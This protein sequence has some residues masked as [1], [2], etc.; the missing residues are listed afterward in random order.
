[1]ANFQP[2]TRPLSQLTK[3]GRCLGAQHPALQHRDGGSQQPT[4]LVPLLPPGGACRTGGNQIAWGMGQQPI[5][6]AKLPAAGD[7]MQRKRGC[8]RSNIL[9]CLNPSRSPLPMRKDSPAAA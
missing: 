3:Q 5:K 7:G 4:H 9:A 1:M 2:S 6:A 8:L